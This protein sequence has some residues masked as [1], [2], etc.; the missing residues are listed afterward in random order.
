MENHRIPTPDGFDAW[1]NAKGLDRK[2]PLHVRLKRFF[3]L[4][5]K[6]DIVIGLCVMLAVSNAVQ[7]HLLKVKKTRQPQKSLDTRISSAM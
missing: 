4:G 6:L 3:Y 1:W 5:A 7:Q 2:H